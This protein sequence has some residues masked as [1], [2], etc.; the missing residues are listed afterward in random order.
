MFFGENRV[1]TQV[2]LVLGVDDPLMDSQ[3]RCSLQCV[4]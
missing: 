2:K 1:S 3:P 4:R